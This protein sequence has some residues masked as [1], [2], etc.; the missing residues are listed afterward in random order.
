MYAGNIHITT[1]TLSAQGSGHTF[2]AVHAATSQLPVLIES[3]LHCA[4]ASRAA[5]S[6]RPI[7]NVLLDSQ[8]TR[9]FAPG[10]AGGPRPLENVQL[11]LQSSHTARP[12]V[13]GATV[14]MSPLEELEVPP[15]SSPM[16]CRLV[17]GAAV[18]PQ[19]L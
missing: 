12:F 1:T 18:S 16:A 8:S 17:P 5:I 14:L 19:P 15:P 13:P 4:N 3:E 9:R 7:N 11:P 2:A 10:T 6:S